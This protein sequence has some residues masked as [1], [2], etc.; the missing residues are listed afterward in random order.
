[1]DDILMNCGCL[2]DGYT[3]ISNGAKL[4][5]PIPFCSIHDCTETAE[6]ADEK[7]AV[8]DKECPWVSDCAEEGRKSCFS[9]P[10]GR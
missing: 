10:R 6:D 3:N 5:V 2:A 4:R 1:M 9:C 7:Y 8:Q